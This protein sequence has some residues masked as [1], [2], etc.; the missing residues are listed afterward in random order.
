[1]FMKESFL[2]KTKKL[3]LAFASLLAAGS[4][5]FGQTGKINYFREFKSDNLIYGFNNASFRLVYNA[6]PLLCT[7]RDIMVTNDKGIVGYVINPSGIAVAYYTKDDMKIYSFKK[8][9]EQL[10][11]LKGGKR[12]QPTAIAYSHDARSFLTGF[13]NGDIVIYDVQKYLP[14]DTIKGA[15]PAQSLT[16]SP[17]N[18]FVASVTGDTVDVWNFETQVLRI[19]LPLGRQANGAAFSSDASMLALTTT[20]RVM[21]YNTR[22]WELIQVVKTD[23]L[24]QYPTFNSDD[25]Y[26][27]YVQNGNNIVVYNV[28][29]QAVEE[30]IAEAGQVT[31]CNFVRSDSSI[32]LITSRPKSIVYW[33]AHTLTPFLGKK[34]DYEVDQKMNGWVKMMQGES[35]EDY[36]IRVN[37]STRARQME[38]FRQETATEMAGDRLT[39]ENPFAGDYNSVDGLL[40]INFNTLPS[41]ALPVPA[42][43]VG[44][45]N[46]AKKLKF[47]NEVYDLS[48]ADEFEL[49]YVEV[50][51]EVTDKVYVYDQIG[52]TKLTPI[53]T[54][55]NFVPLEI[56]QQASA[57]EAKLQEVKEEII[58][59]DKQDNLI[60]E[61]TLIS[62]DAKVVPDVDAEGN[63]ILNY[64]VGYKYEVINREFSMSEDF[65]PGVYDVT[66]SNAAM[67]LMKIIKQSFEE[68]DFAKYLE[69]GKRVKITITGSA[70]GAPIRTKKVYDGRY[71]EYTDEPYRQN[72]ELEAM[73]V[74]SATGISTNPQLAFIRA[75]SVKDYLSKNISTLQQTRN[76]YS[77]NIEVSEERGGEFRKIHIQFT[78]IDAFKQK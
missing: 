13:S 73:T 16:L 45:F 28:R 1:M 72:G 65:P 34:L 46:D 56:L 68:G 55:L 48:S 67:S 52:R 61:N 10:F 44:S 8:I 4:A 57:E 66:K 40:T 59:G 43:E 35:M 9:D 76:D 33:D 70:D 37:D 30:R 7:Y 36:R 31:G 14:R 50:T 32:Y 41:I 26:L 22:N 62:V 5:A 21:I 47:A 27:A 3:A 60:S 23:T 42:T 17:N 51:N 64:Q 24:V 39:V 19:Q 77:Y 58:A 20:D 54:D 2:R 25:K 38:L 11:R 53:E 6:K 69:A 74:T 18:Y 12:L 78:I 49:V 71:G 15:K 29:K 75:A 63:K